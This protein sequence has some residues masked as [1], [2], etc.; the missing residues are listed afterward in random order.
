MSFEGDID[1]DHDR[2][3]QYII[4][5]EDYDKYAE[6]HEAFVDLMRISLLRDDF[7]IIGFSCDDPN[8]LLWINWVKD[9]NDKAKDRQSDISKKYYINVDDNALPEDKRLLLE[10]HQIQ[11]LNL[12][13]IY[14]FATTMKERISEFFNDLSLNQNAFY[15]YERVWAE[16]NLFVSKINGHN[17]PTYNKDDISLAWYNM[18]K[19]PVAF[20]DKAFD[21]RRAD[22][23]RNF[24]RVVKDKM[25]DTDITRLCFMAA[26]RGNV[27]FGSFLP[28]N[29]EIV[30]SAFENVDDPGLDQ[31]VSENNELQTLLEHG[32]C[33]I[34]AFSP[35][36]QYFYGL[37]KRFYC[38]DFSDIEDYISSWHPTY[39]IDKVLKLIYTGS[40]SYKT[41]QTIR[42]LSDREGY[43]NPQEY[44]TSLLM[45]SLFRWGLSYD[46]IQDKVFEDINNTI[47]DLNTHEKGLVNFHEYIYDLE[48]RLHGDDTVSPLGDR[49]ITIYFSSINKAE[50]AA[51]KMINFLAKTGL[52]PNFASVNIIDKNKWYLV[53]KNAYRY[54]PSACL[55]YS[56]TF[57]E[58]DLAVRIGQLY[59][60][61]SQLVFNSTISEL[62]SRIM[63]ACLLYPTQVNIESLLVYACY[64]MKV[65]P[66]EKWRKVFKD[67]FY[68]NEW[69][70]KDVEYWHKNVRPFNFAYEG[71]AY[72]DDYDFKQDLASKILSKQ[73][74]LT[75]YDNSLLLTCLKGKIISVDNKEKITRL[76][77]LKPTLPIAMIIINFRRVLSSRSFLKWI[78]QVPD[79][80]L[81]DKSVIVVFAK[82]AKEHRSLRPKLFDLVGKNSTLWNTGIVLDEEE[83]K[84]TQIGGVHTSFIENIERFI[85]LPKNVTREIYTKAIKRLSEIEQA[86]RQRWINEMSEYWC[87]V[88]VSI[89]CFL[90]K[91][92]AEL[93]LEKD[94]C[95]FLGKCKTLYP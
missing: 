74:R 57:S 12:F 9:I 5:K 73:K 27:P 10:N 38:F 43:T 44:Y 45:L 87:M 33:N 82:L 61:D 3:T 60:Y 95:D 64:F 76:S 65:V 46:L 8:F 52:N 20:M 13:E 84:V 34:T 58:K 55:L 86:V 11:I 79:E 6:K 59:A 93:S 1:F 68:K 25:I 39:K 94:Y 29:K 78:R 23:L 85:S 88:L 17:W 14:T 26:N 62:L 91:H 18:L 22:I 77:K 56:S 69:Y 50:E 81:N 30:E 35:E 31:L 47:K 72:I 4:T 92:K 2:H 67:I 48:T 24:G 90:V 54:Y 19:N 28:D 7:C 66:P 40:I 70:D 51:I 80:V 41:I 32:D 53:V 63:N 49:S 37:L 36:K 75:S 83:Q 16:S 21:G 15:L 89:R 71:L 42:D